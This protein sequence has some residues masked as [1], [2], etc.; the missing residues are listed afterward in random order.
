VTGPPEPSSFAVE[1]A[2]SKSVAADYMFAAVDCKNAAEKIRDSN[3]SYM[4]GAGY[5]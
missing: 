1:T 2:K 5:S 4:R 3:S